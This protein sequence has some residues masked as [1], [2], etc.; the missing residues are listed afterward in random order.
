LSAYSLS[1]G[2]G[3]DAIASSPIT[4]VPFIG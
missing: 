4:F 1:L 3:E 2:G